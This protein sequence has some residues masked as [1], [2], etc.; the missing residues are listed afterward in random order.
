MEFSQMIG[1][2]VPRLGKALSVSILSLLFVISNKVGIA[3]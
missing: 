1:I 3:G 2:A